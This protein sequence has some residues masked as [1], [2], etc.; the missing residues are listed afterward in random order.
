LLACAGLLTASLRNLQKQDF[1]FLPQD[2]VVV[3]IK[4]L[5]P[6][7]TQEHLQSA[8]RSLQDRLRQIPGVQDVSFALYAPLGG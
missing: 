3:S 8:Y 6:T 2:R 4:P 1:G 5:S 7:Y